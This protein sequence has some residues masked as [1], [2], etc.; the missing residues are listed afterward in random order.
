MSRALTCVPFLLLLLPA[1]G[2]MPERVL[3]E[4]SALYQEDALVP[5]PIAAVRARVLAGALGR[6]LE[7]R[8]SP[9]GPGIDPV[10]G[11]EGRPGTNLRTA[12]ELERLV[13]TGELRLVTRWSGVGHA[14]ALE[15][16]VRGPLPARVVG[17]DGRHLDVTTAAP[18][19]IEVVFRSVALPP[20]STSSY[21]ECDGVP[22]L[23][24]H[25]DLRGDEA[26]VALVSLAEPVPMPQH[27]VRR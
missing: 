9:C 27:G 6:W 25:V 26:T 4:S 21:L 23:A 13:A 22:R 18:W 2:P 15:R 7:L 16:V 11:F 20:S 8:V 12:E 17:L 1:P 5:R 3:A 24:I 19:P 10:P 14:G